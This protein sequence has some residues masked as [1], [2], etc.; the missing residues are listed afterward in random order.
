MNIKMYLSNRRLEMVKES[1]A[2]E[3]QK[4]MINSQ[5]QS[6]QAQ[7]NQVNQQLLKLDVELEVLDK[8]EASLNGAKEVGKCSAQQQ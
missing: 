6:L 1:Q 3:K 5:A 4:Q 8:L 2:L 7:S